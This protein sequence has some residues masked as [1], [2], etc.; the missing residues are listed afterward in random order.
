MRKF[1]TK[2]ASIIKEIYD[3]I[4]MGFKKSESDQRRMF[5]PPDPLDESREKILRELAKK[6]KAVKK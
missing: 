1:L 3:A 5:N 4:N 6:K 2:F